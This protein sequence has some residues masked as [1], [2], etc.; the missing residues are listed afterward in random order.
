[1]HAAESGVF[2]KLWYLQH[3]A[4]LQAARLIQGQHR[5][6]GLG[7]PLPERPQQPSTVRTVEGQTSQ[8]VVQEDAHSL[9][10]LCHEH[11]GLNVTVEHLKPAAAQQTGGFKH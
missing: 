8:T 1:M 7:E 11:T 6:A 4:D 3:H 5:V 2:D 10:C 9:R